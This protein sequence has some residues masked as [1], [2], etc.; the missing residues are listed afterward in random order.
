[1]KLYLLRHGVAVERGTPGFRVDSDR[2]LTPKGE[3]GMK[4]IAAGIRALD[5]VPRVI[6]S[7]P[8]VRARR[9]AEIVASELGISEDLKFSKHLAANADPTALVD[10]LTQDFATCASV[11]LV[12]HEP[13]M[14]G[15]ISV[16]ISGDSDSVLVFKKGGLC[17][18][19]IDSLEYGRCGTMDWLLT[20]RQLKRLGN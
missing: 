5:F 14:S 18:L 15:L 6:L 17:R 13:Y 19:D 12:G 11:M 2:P 4:R 7:S 8:Y 20:P 3:R 1:M 10:E 16:L 9:T